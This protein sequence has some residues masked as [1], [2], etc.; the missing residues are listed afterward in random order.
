MRKRVSIRYPKIIRYLVEGGVLKTMVVHISPKKIPSGYRITSAS[1]LIHTTTE[2]RE[3]LNL[4][5]TDLLVEVGDYYCIRKKNCL[6]I[7]ESKP[8]PSVEQT[9]DS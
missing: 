4:K 9:K 1:Q 8:T 3:K 7:S 2:Q 5:T 6:Y